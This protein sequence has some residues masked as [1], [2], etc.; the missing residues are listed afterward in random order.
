MWRTPWQKLINRSEKIVGY[1][2][3]LI[4][5]RYLLSDEIAFVASH[6][7][8]LVDTNHPL[9]K[10]TKSLIGGT[11]SVSQLSGLL[12]LLISKTFNDPTLSIN[13]NQHSMAEIVETVH[14][15]ICIHK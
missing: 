4:N 10:I 15:A 13:S 3:S 6:I 2:S 12:V 1:P 11:H 14:A 8:K 5:I 9:L 7:R